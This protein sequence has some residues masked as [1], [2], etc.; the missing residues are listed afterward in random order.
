[1]SLVCQC[2]QHQVRAR[3]NCTNSN[4]DH[5]PCSNHVCVSGYC[6]CHFEKVDTLKELENT[7]D[8]SRSESPYFYVG[9]SSQSG[10]E[11]L[12]YLLKTETCKK[13][14]QQNKPIVGTTKQLDRAYYWPKSENLEKSEQRLLNYAY[15]IDGNLN[16]EK[17]AKKR[18]DSGNAYVKFYKKNSV[19]WKYQ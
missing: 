4:C 3:T 8:S 2:G 7:I 16:N 1:M 5:K 15:E 17:N 18:K 10:N 11:F 6:T 14:I 9:V 13:Y 12:R 19:D